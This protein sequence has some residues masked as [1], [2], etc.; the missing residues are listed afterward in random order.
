MIFIYLLFAHLLG[1]FVFQ[2]LALIQ[3]KKRTQK[4]IFLH[5]VIHFIIS[6]FILTIFLQISLKQLIGVLLLISISHY[7]IDLAKINFEKKS[8]IRVNS[9]LLDQLG[10]LIVLSGISIYL[11]RALGAVSFRY[12]DVFIF[13]ILYIVINKVLPVFS[14]Q[15]VL[16]KNK[17]AV[18][19]TQKNKSNQYM[20]VFLSISLIYFLFKM[21]L[22]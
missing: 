8:K 6:F 19:K 18:M 11:S 13:F 7:L 20:K 15:K 14:L 3:Y 12:F 9:F 10:H 5:T 2:S 4:G 1:D 21:F 17:N 22:F 16:E